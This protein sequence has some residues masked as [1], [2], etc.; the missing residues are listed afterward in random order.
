MRAFAAASSSSART[1]SGGATVEAALG[2]LEGRLQVRPRGEGLARGLGVQ[3]RGALEVFAR[4]GVLRDEPDVGVSLRLEPGRDEAVHL[5]A[6]FVEDR[7]VRRV[8]QQGVPEG[9]LGLAGDAALLL[10][11]EDLLLLEGL[12]LA[13][14]VALQEPR[15]RARPE[16]GSKDARRAHDLL[17]VA[18]HAIEPHLQHGLHG[19]RQLV[20]AGG[21]RANQLL[22]EQRVAAS[23][24]DDRGAHP[25]LCAWQGDA[26]ELVR[27]AR[28][29]RGERQ[30][31]H[32]LGAPQL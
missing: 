7:R 15:D 24:L 4:V 8:T 32:V 10:A 14:G 6:I 21:R 19:E 23:A 22:Q 3:L 1:L 28:R 25:G 11:R 26:D 18:R 13:L 2:Q 16:D 29:E 17:Q 12:E 9:P 20:L 31:R 30:P 5:G 27:R